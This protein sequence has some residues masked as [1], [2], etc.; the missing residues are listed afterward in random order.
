MHALGSNE[1]SNGYELITF[2]QNVEFQGRINEKP[3]RLGC[4]VLNPWKIKMWRLGSMKKIRAWSSK[5]LKDRGKESC[6]Y[7]IEHG[8]ES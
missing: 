6:F 1:P 3:W 4:K 7:G 8:T 2:E 5:Y